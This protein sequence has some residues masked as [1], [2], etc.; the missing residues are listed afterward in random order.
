MVVGDGALTLPAVKT[1]ETD[2]KEELT[3]G[4][5]RGRT[6]LAGI[7]AAHFSHHVSTGLLNPLLPFI[8]DSFA[9]SYAQSGLLVSAFSLS[10]GLSNAPIGVLADRVGSRPIIVVG[11]LLTGAVRAALLV[12][13]FPARVRGAAMGLHITGGHLSF[14]ATPMVAAILVSASGTWRAPFFW[15]GLAPILFGVVVW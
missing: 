4:S 10:L 5:R 8:R 3:L 9:L 11:L 2:A 1:V 14:F 6:L 7:T 15:F 13:A 12:R